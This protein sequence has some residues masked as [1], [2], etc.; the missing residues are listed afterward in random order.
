MSAATASAF[1]QALA[2]HAR[3]EATEI[4]GRFFKTGEGQ[5][6]A[7]DKFIG[8]KVPQTRQVCKQFADLPLPEVQ[9]LLDSPV[10]EHRLGAVIILANRYAKGSPLDQQATFDFY[11][12]NVKAQ[13][14][15]NWDIVD[16]SCEYVIGAHL[17]GRPQPT[18]ILRQ[19]AASDNLWARRVA[20]VST[21][22]FLKKGEPAPTLEMATMLLHDKHD[23][24]QKAVGWSLREMGKRVD[25]QLL[26][27]FLD[28]HAH[29]MP[30]TALRYAIERLSPARRRHY[31]QLKLAAH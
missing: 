29:N 12:K 18:K 5:Y 21:F 30:R 25:E 14:I 6:G 7:G 16:V 23:L 10:H 20:M 11:L 1:K 22:A 27:A 17:V 8:V 9:K 3:P 15:N 19:L 4:L 26:T 31:M 28:Q 2:A 13:R 24:L